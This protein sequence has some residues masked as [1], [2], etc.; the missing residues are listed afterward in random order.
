MRIPPVSFSGVFLESEH[1][2]CADLNFQNSL[3][4]CARLLGGLA[5]SARNHILPF[6]M[7]IMFPGG[8][9]HLLTG[10]V[11]FR[12]LHGVCGGFIHR[13]LPTVIS[14]LHFACYLYKIRF[15]VSFTLSPLLVVQC[16][17]PVV[18]LPRRADGP[19]G[20]L[21]HATAAG[22]RTLRLPPREAVRCGHL[23]PRDGPPAY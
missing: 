21:P 17:R 13:C 19:V 22:S 23:T 6:S 7:L 16:P 15:R 18:L 12:S 4:V 9:P 20:P 14:C 11:C 1:G 2:R 3:F 8:S 5:P 10:C